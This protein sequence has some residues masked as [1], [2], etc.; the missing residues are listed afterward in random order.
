MFSRIINNLFPQWILQRRKILK[1]DFSLHPPVVVYQMGSVGSSTVYET[2]LLS[3]IKNPV[4]HVHY[5]YDQGIRAAERFHKNLGWKKTPDDLRLYETLRLKMARDPDVRWKIITPVREPVSRGVSSFFNNARTHNPGI[6]D[7][8]GALD[9]NGTMFALKDSFLGRGVENPDYSW[10][11]DEFQNALGIDPLQHF[12]DHE[13][14]YTIARKNNIEVLFF[15]Q[16]DLDRVFLKGA[17][18]LLNLDSSFNPKIIQMN[19]AENKDYHSVYTKVRQNFKLPQSILRMI[20][21]DKYVR[22]FYAPEE[23]DIF[24]NRWRS[25]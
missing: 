16:E 8:S 24:L 21:Q 19:N 25:P 22:H 17:A 13:K 23:I 1:Q 10:F 14:G 6:F 2:L 11:R 12:F 4:F 7:S 20:Y 5:L 18:R 15:R 3:G 9:Y